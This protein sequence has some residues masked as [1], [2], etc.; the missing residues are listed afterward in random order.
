MDF[1]Y[2]TY[3]YLPECTDGCGAI[4]GWLDSKQAASE[5]AGNHGRARGHRW[6]VLERMR[7]RQPPRE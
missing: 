1:D 6:R 7:E 2:S 5:A 4:T 3:E